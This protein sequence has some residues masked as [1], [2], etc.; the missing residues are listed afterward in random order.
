MEFSLI[1]PL[2]L[3]VVFTVIAFAMMMILNEMTFYATFMAGRAASVGSG[4]AQA[5]AS[6]IL[7]GIRVSEGAGSAD[8]LVMRGSYN[9]REFLTGGEGALSN[10]FAGYTMLEAD[11]AMHRWSNCQLGGDNALNYCP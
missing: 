1:L 11:L 10:P 3:G 9:M 4:G 7:P 2:F 8:T 5:A 6:E